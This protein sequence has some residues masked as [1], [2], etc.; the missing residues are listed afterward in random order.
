MKTLL[1]N[2]ACFTLAIFTDISYASSD[3]LSLNSDDENSHPSFGKVTRP[4]SP[5]STPE[6]STLTRISGGQGFLTRTT[7]EGVTEILLIRDICFP[8]QWGCVGAAQKQGEF[9]REAFIRGV[10]EKLGIKVFPQYIECIASWERTNSNTD[11]TNNHCYFYIAR[12]THN[13]TLPTSPQFPATVKW[14]PVDVLHKTLHSSQASASKEITPT[15]SYPI[16]MSHKTLTDSDPIIFKGIIPILRHY[17]TM[18]H[19]PPNSALMLAS[20]FYEE[21]CPDFESSKRQMRYH[22]FN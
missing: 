12:I 19:T 20:S 2:L 6:T 5:D 22:F 17:L 18:S 14:F 10:E 1:Q 15:L 21:E 4:P 3:N 7:L 11:G 8:E 9:S 16:V 13:V